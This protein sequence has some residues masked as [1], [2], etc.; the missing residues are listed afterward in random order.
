[1]SCNYC[2]GNIIEFDNP[3]S[4]YCLQCGRYPNKAPVYKVRNSHD[5]KT[6]NK[7]PRE[8]INCGRTKKI[9]AKDLCIGCYDSAIHAG[10]AGSEGFKKGLKRAAQRFNNP[11]YSGK[12]GTYPRDRKGLAA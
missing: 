2:G 6:K 11:D 3:L 4:D 10:P 5:R 12:R 9:K 1:M 8:C 7:L